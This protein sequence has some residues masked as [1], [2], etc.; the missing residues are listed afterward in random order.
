MSRGTGLLLLSLAALFEVA[1]D[2]I[3]RTGLRSSHPLSRIIFFLVGAGLLFAYGWSVNAPAWNFG[4]LL[5]IYVVLF[6]V[7]AQIVS[8]LAF[9]QQP[10]R[11]LLVGGALIV[12]GG[13]VIALAK[14]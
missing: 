11:A 3:V 14:H 9:G 12:S 13:I 8:W 5:G 1:G 10:S 6:F 4:Q 7:L 2:A